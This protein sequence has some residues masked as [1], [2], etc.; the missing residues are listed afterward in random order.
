M[1]DNAAP[2]A[3]APVIDTPEAEPKETS[4]AE[5]AELFGPQDPTL[6]A[7]AKA[8]NDDARAKVRHRARSQQ[9]SPEDAPRIAELTKRLRETEAERDALKPKT[10]PVRVDTPL[11][12]VAAPVAESGAARQAVTPAPM[13]PKPSEE[14][15][16]VEGG[17]DTYNAYI[18]DLTDWKYEQREAAREA[19]QQQ[20]QQARQQAASQQ[21]WQQAHATYAERLTAFKATHPDFDT[22]LT[23]HGAAQLPAAPIAAILAS[24]HGPA[25]SYHLMQHP[26]QLAELALLFDGKTPDGEAPS[27]ALVAHATRWLSSRAAKPEPERVPATVPSLTL[28]PKPPNPVKAG[29]A[30]ADTDGSGDDSMSIGDHEKAYGK[31]WKR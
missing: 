31:R 13:R 27:A 25:W 17:Y 20:A 3:D 9:A 29:A 8:K 1:A 6:D 5:H 10:P 18:E 23:Q 2:I 26:D 11:G 30:R 7:E 14:S 16:G 22:L 19:Q 4:L 28:A 15:I 24:E 12:T 21:A